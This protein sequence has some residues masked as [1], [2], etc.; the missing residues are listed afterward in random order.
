ME[1]RLAK[2]LFD[3]KLLPV[4]AIAGEPATDLRDEPAHLTVRASTAQAPA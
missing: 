4:D 1:V 2:P 3:P